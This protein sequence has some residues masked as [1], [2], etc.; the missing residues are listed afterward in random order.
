MRACAAIAPYF[1]PVLLAFV[2]MAGAVAVIFNAQYLANPHFGTQ[3]DYWGLIL[4]AYGSAQVAAI[5][6]A[7]LLMRAPQPWYG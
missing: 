6:T 7:L 5:A 2:T 4:A 3:A 1:P